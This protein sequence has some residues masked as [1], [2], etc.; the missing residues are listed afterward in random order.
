M[1]TPFNTIAQEQREKEAWQVMGE[2]ETAD[3]GML[4]R[5]VSINGLDLIERMRERNCKGV[6]DGQ[7]GF[8][9]AIRDRLAERGA[10]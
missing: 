8:L 6:T 10:L 5:H 3:Q 1:P 2:I 9:R 4:E 7:L